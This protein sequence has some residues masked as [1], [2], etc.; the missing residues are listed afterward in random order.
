[1]WWESFNVGYLTKRTHQIAISFPTRVSISTRILSEVE[2]FASPVLYQDWAECGNMRN[3]VGKILHMQIL[4]ECARGSNFR[5]RYR[6]RNKTLLHG[7]P[8]LFRYIRNNTF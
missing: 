7:Y 1:M 6:N 4:K 5:P 8:N 3:T 2:C